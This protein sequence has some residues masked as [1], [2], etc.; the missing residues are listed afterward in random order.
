LVNAGKV[1]ARQSCLSRAV[2]GEI[3]LDSGRFLRFKNPVKYIRGFELTYT[4]A[5][6][7]VFY[8]EQSMTWAQPA[9]LTFSQSASAILVQD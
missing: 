5:R 1:N 9:P 6:A 4:Q 8:R 2:F 3:H 7:A